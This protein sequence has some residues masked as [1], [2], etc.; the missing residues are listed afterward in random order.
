MIKINQKILWVFVQE[1]DANGTQAADKHTSSDVSV[2]ASSC[3]KLLPPWTRQHF[4]V[5]SFAP[6]ENVGIAT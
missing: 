2:E 1:A 4:I 3:V 5:L 6:D